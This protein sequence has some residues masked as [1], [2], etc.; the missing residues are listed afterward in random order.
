[1]DK[2]YLRG[3]KILD[4]FK[5]NVHPYYIESP[6][7]KLMDSACCIMG[8][9]KVDSQNCHLKMNSHIKMQMVVESI[10]HFHN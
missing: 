10:E 9:Y 2:G 5:F 8:N 7:R 1:M 4:Q 6:L 3:L